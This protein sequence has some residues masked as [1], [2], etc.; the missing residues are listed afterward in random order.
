MAN[1]LSLTGRDASPRRPLRAARCDVG[2][3]RLGEPSLPATRRFCAAFTLIELVV[4]IAIIALL[5]AILLP[6]LQEAR[7]RAHRVACKSNLRQWAVGLMSY[8]GDNSG[9]LLRTATHFPPAYSGTPYP[10]IATVYDNPLWT[11]QLTAQ[12]INPYVSRVT[13]AS[14]ASNQRYGGIWLC[15][16][17]SHG[18]KTI[19]NVTSAS[20][21]QFGYAYYARGFVERLRDPTTGSDRK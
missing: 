6:S 18:T 11:G 3:G 1:D 5:A 14:A 8:S 13:L 16:S 21:I 10:H 20:Y 7:G 17:F 19:P 12:L 2:Y 4:V 9:K 15:P